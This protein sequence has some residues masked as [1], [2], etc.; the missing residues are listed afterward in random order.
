MTLACIGASHIAIRNLL[1]TQIAPLTIFSIVFPTIQAIV[2]IA[3]KAH[4]VAIFT[5]LVIV[6]SQVQT[7]FK[8]PQT[9][10]HIVCKPADI[11]INNHFHQ[12]ICESVFLLEDN[13]IPSI[14]SLKSHQKIPSTFQILEKTF[15]NSVKNVD[16]NDAIAGLCFS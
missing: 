6:L 10:H 15:T 2:I 16:V 1:N 3:L 7:N 12:F 8:T 13:Q 9:T 4:E 11:T 5:V 14:T